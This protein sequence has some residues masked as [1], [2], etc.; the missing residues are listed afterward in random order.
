VPGAQIV[1]LRHEGARL[2]NRHR[3]GGQQPACGCAAAGDRR[4][5]SAVDRLAYD[6]RHRHAPLS[7]DLEEPGMP[8]GVEQELEAMIERHVH[9]RSHTQSATQSAA[10]SLTC[11]RR[12]LLPDGSRKPESMP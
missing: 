4:R 2:C 11:V 12:M 1:E 6:R 9:V 10:S 7:S 5:Q 8:I 3:I